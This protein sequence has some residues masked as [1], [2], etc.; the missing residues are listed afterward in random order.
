MARVYLSV[1]AGNEPHA[2]WA[3]DC[4]IPNIDVSDFAEQLGPEMAYFQHLRGSAGGFA[5]G[6][7]G[8]LALS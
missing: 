3:F 2:Y 7:W 6:S 4:T 5:G 8:S 1:H